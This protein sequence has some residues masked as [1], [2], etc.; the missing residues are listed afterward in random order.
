MVME[1][2][3]KKKNGGKKWGLS[4]LAIHAVPGN[5]RDSSDGQTGEVSPSAQSGARQHTNIPLSGNAAS[6]ESVSVSGVTLAT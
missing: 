2:R 3:D 6:S 5:M 1:C 4:S